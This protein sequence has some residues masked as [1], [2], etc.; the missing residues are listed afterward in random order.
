MPFISPGLLKA[1]VDGSTDFDVFAP[2]SG[3]PRGIEPLCAVYS[4]TCGPEILDSM[5]RGDLAAI[6]FHTA[7]RVGVLPRAAVEHYGPPSH[8]FLNINEPSDL[9][10]AETAWQGTR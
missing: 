10:R 6:S 3:G 4:P 9:A 8:L 1:L 5:K 2:E 7:V